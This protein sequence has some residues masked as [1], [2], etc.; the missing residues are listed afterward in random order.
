MDID[1]GDASKFSPRDW[2]LPDFKRIVNRMQTFAHEVDGWNAVFLEN[3]DQPRSVSRFTPHGPEHRDL[4]AKM[5]ATLLCTLGGTLFV[6]Q[7]Q[8]LG[9]GN[10]PEFWGPEEYKDVE[11]VNF[12]QE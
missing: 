12:V 9:M 2:T 11:T 5:L 4:A 3:H 7:G 6:Y 1:I 8:E 10:V